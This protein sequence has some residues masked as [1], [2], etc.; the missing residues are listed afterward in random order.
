MDQL[1]EKDMG[2]GT[3]RS[4]DP[5]KNFRIKISLQR[6]SSSTIGFLAKSSEGEPTSA[7]GTT[8]TTN[9]YGQTIMESEELAI[10]WQQ[11]FFSQREMEFYGFEPN[12]TSVMDYKYHAEVDKL[13]KG[14]GRPNKRI[15]SYVGN[16]RF[17]SLEE[18]YVTVTTSNREMRTELAERIMEV[19]QRKNVD[20]SNTASSWKINGGKSVTGMKIV[21]EKPT[22]EFQQNHHVLTT[23]VHT[24][25]IMADL[26]PEEQL[27]R[28]EFERKI[29]TVE[30]DDNSVMRV[31]PDF[32]GS[33]PPYRLEEG[34]L[35]RDV[36]EFRI[37]HV[38]NSVS[39]MEAM[40]E[41]KVISELYRKHQVYLQSLVSE[42]FEEVPE[43]VFRLNVYGE[44]VSAQ[45][46]QQNDLHVEFLLDVPRD[47]SC[48]PAQ[49]LSG[50]THTCR[51]TLV[52]DVEFAYFCQPFHYHMFL[53]MENI[54]D[55]EPLEWPRI[56]VHVISSDTWGRRRTEGYGYLTIPS[57]PGT[58]TY[59]VQCW[60]PLGNA[61]YPAIA[62]ELRRFFIGGNPELEDI[63]YVAVPSTFEGN[64]LNKYGVRTE[65]A[66]SVTIKFNSILQC[67]AFKDV[68]TSAA[69]SK[70]KLQNAFQLAKG[71]EKSDAIS[72]VMGKYAF[73]RARKKMQLARENVPLEIRE[74]AQKVA[75]KQQYT[76]AEN[77]K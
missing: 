74:S 50:C 8:T 4:R 39:K 71:K 63:S 21:E 27:G 29:C 15:F 11:K 45:S 56:F 69:V 7:Q 55:L 26:S 19:R 41:A 36:W 67:K 62:A 40:R 34:G 44:V 5:I 31:T 70:K 60:R 2:G 42:K 46:F 48:D 43:R 32:T 35:G 24:L 68:S 59:T 47:W 3:Y 52:D 65:S 22:V 64:R 53:D 72:G 54:K 10:Q 30:F 58:H 12:C 17:A 25:V 75:T 23:P 13:K 77:K 14:S 66:G 76:S 61:G 57:S 9:Q 18:A 6:L 73:H 49:L 33:R 28:A 1:Y 38:S 16:E 51:T 37:D 20:S